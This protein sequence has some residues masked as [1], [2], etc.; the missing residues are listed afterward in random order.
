MDAKTQPSQPP[1]LPA[2]YAQY[3]SSQPQQPWAQQPAP[4]YMPHPQTNVS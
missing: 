4:V 1:P 3:L 2:Q